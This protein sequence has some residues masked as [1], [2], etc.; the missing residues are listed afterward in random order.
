MKPSLYPQKP[1]L[2][3][4]DEA[5]I[6]KSYE[7]TLKS[8]GIHNV[9]SCRDPRNVMSIIADR[10]LWVILLDLSMPYIS[11]EEILLNITNEHP[12]IPVIIITGD[13][14][15][16]TAV[17]CMKRGA[18][19]Y[20]VKPVEKNRLVSGVKRVIEIRELQHENQMLK[21]RILDGTLA[22]PEAFSAII[23]NN[24]TMLSLFQYAESIAISPKP[25]LITGETG[26]GKE[27]M[28]RAIHTLSERTGEF[29][30]IN[31]AGIDD[32][33]FADTLFGHVKGA[34]T[35]ADQAR[36]GIVEK[37]SGG[38]MVL[39]EIG[40]LNIDSQVKLL[41]IIQ[42]G[43]YYPLGSDL[44]QKS[45]ARIIV[46]T[47]RHL[48]T[49]Q[50][51]ERFRK[52]LFFRLRAHHIHI[53]PLRERLDDI[54][55]LLEHFL[56]EIAQSLEKKTPS[57]PE[58]LITLLSNYDFPGNIRELR[59]MVY[60]ALS[61]HKSKNISMKRFLLNMDRGC[62][63]TGRD[64]TFDQSESP[65]SLQITGMLPTLKQ[66]TRS[67]ITEAMRRTDNN[68]SMAARLL[69]ISRQTLARHLNS[70]LK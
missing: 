31:A 54:P 35:G 3:I 67:L 37:A 19:D 65:S 25:V 59:V 10:N 22:R 63:H 57:Y 56:E 28:A 8:E 33:V 53:P 50:N 64:S 49:L 36:K 43:E 26:V 51:S 21:Q 68:Q 13:N 42:E 9:L 24:R 38:T 40:D 58:E 30:S 12:D 46:S 18:F 66:A 5:D 20:M 52:D 62:D 4:D 15:V 14:E 7:L 48:Q 61:T 69:G 11:G 47:N 32:N 60:D 39:E 34:F 41:R 27:L 1:V 70:E 29:I 45:D 23:T 17:R 55:L 44:P 2:I 6:L 16:D